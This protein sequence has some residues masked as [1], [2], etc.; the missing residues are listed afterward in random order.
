LPKGTVE[1]PENGKESDDTCDIAVITEE[2]TD[3]EEDTDEDD[4][5]LSLYRLVVAQL[6]SD[7]SCLDSIF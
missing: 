3:L 4:A 1:S 7:V 5:S 2:A 6:V